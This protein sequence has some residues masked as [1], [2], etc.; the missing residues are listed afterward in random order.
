MAIHQDICIISIWY[1]YILNFFFFAFCEDCIFSQ[2]RL[3]EQ[4]RLKAFML[5]L[6]FPSIPLDTYY[7]GMSI[8]WMYFA[9][10]ISIPMFFFLNHHHTL[11]FFL[12]FQSWP[13][14]VLFALACH[15]IPF[16]NI[17]V[18]FYMHDHA[19]ACTN[20]LH[21]TSA[22]NWKTD[23]MTLSNSHPN[24]HSTISNTRTLAHHW[25]F[26]ALCISSNILSLRS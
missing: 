14:I 9:A 11:C 16:K 1:L 7:I 17:S 10:T 22:E 13:H 20:Q 23:H 19:I 12:S 24:A 25:H 8:S 18:F 26:F 3:H 5:E 2:H 6:S 15:A 21:V 4:F